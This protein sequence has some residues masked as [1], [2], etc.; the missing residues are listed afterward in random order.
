MLEKKLNALEADYRATLSATRKEEPIP[1]RADPATTETAITATTTTA[2]TTTATT[3]V[4]T[5]TTETTRE[6]K[7]TNNTNSRDFDDFE[8]DWSQ[9][10]REEQKTEEQKTEERPI[11]PLSREN[12][13]KIKSYMKHVKVRPP[14]WAAGLPE[15]VW[16]AKMTGVLSGPALPNLHSAGKTKKSKKRTQK[17]I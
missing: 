2:T 9:L 15:E 10:K 7:D 12:V 13:E 11:K 5:E 6:C 16:L 3:V 8:A 14:P 1:I 17:K 4:T